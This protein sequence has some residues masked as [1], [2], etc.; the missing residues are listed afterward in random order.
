LIVTVADTSR[1]AAPEP[2]AIRVT[3]QGPSI[4]LV[5]GSAAT[6][7]DWRPLQRRLSNDHLV[8]A[9]DRRGPS[10]ET[11]LARDADRPGVEGHARDL[12]EI[13]E[14]V[15]APVV[16]G[17]SFGAVVVLEAALLRPE[18]Q[19]ALVLCEP[20]LPSSSRPGGV[21][22]PYRE[23]YDSICAREGTGAGALFFLRHVLGRDAFEALPERARHRIA[24]LGPA[25][26]RD[27]NALDAHPIDYGAYAT[28]QL[29]CLLLGGDRS[30]AFFQETL[31]ALESAMSGSRRET[32]PNAGHAMP[33]D[34]PRAFHA[35]LSRFVTE[36]SPE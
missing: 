34:N 36:L 23:E 28:I 32:I 22:S 14:G 11:P 12:I 10:D 7:D 26:R 31:R 19:R 1:T 30:P 2:L 16:C 8:V 25:I 15:A 27:A 6:S 33:G 13:L 5:H 18:L 29:P 35:A 3:G 17:S 9:Y 21:P 20:P 4:V 24:G